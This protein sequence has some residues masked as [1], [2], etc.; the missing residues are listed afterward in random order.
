MNILAKIL[1]IFVHV[2]SEEN[3]NWDVYT[4]RVRGMSL[5]CNF[6]WNDF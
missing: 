1:Q 6:K 2:V 5:G 4:S 3:E